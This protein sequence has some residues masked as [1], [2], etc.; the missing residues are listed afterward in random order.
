M[1]IYDKEQ[2]V[3]YRNFN[4]GVKYLP[5]MRNGRLWYPAGKVFLLFEKGNTFR[6]SLGK[7]FKNIIKYR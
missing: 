3:N 5:Q 2:I 6:I 4:R 1:R 7:P